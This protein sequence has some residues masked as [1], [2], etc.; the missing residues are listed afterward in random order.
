MT[1]VYSLSETQSG[2]DWQ[3]SFAGVP[4]P[5]PLGA[6]SAG[7]LPNPISTVAT[8]SHLT[9]DRN[10]SEREGHTVSSGGALGHR[11]VLLDL[12][13]VFET[14]FPVVAIG[15]HYPGMLVFQAPVDAWACHHTNPRAHASCI[16]S[17]L[18]FLGV[19]VAVASYP[20]SP[21]HTPPSLTCPAT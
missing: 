13:R 8:L 5:Q 7:G 15:L 3:R 2:Q 1:P 4:M 19:D 21:G 12:H 17:E 6:H 20:G 18:Q 9:R 14:P 11:C 10:I 16:I